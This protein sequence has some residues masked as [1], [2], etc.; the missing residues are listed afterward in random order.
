MCAVANLGSI[1][2]WTRAAG[3]RRLHPGSILALADQLRLRRC[4]GDAYARNRVVD[5]QRGIGGQAGPVVGGLFV[6]AV[7]WRG[8]F[9]VNIPVCLAGMVLAAAY[10]DRREKSASSTG[11][12]LLGQTLA[13]VAVLGLVGGIIEG[14]SRGWKPHIVLTGITFFGVFGLLFQRRE[15]RSEAPVLPPALFRNTVISSAMFIGFVLSF[16]ALGLVFALSVYFQ[17]VQG[18]SSVEA[19]LAFVPFAVTVTIA[20]LIGTAAAARFGSLIAMTGALVVGACGYLLLARMDSGSSYLAMLPAQLLARLGVGAAIPIA[21]S[22]LLSATSKQQSGIASGGLNAIR[23]M[24]AAIGVAAFGALM[25]GDPSSGFRIAV[26]ICAALLLI[27]AGSAFL[28]LRA[29]KMAS[30]GPQ[31]P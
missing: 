29:E 28:V 22:M 7:G 23:Q 24:G 16:C 15:A 12:D 3:R 13:V 2:P 30:R 9:L 8:I 4:A 17:N 25:V 10:R 31:Q 27:A 26:A 1:D 19:G 6:G 18:Y 21:T 11:F 20:N 5:S 14:G